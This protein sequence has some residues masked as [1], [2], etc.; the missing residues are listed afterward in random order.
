VSGF[1]GAGGCGFAR[2]ICFLR[3]LGEVAVQLVDRARRTGVEMQGDEQM[4]IVGE[5]PA[6][7]DKDDQGKGDDEAEESDGGPRETIQLRMK[8]RA[9]SDELDDLVTG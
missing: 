9:S 6:P 1:V 3:V 5:S 7:R 8:K 4:R 2:I